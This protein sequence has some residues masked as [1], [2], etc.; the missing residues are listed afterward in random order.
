MDEGEEFRQDTPE[1]EG[2]VV[3]DMDGVLVDSEPVHK[4]AL[5]GV[6][7]RRGLRI[8]DSEYV[9]ITGLNHE[10]FWRWI[11]DNFSLPA[12]AGSYAIEYEDLLLPMLATGLQAA[13][14]VQK[15]I[16]LLHSKGIPMAV[17]SSSSRRV[18]D[19]TLSTIGLSTAFRVVLSGRDVRRGK[20]DPEIYLLA[21]DRL[22][23]RPADCVAVEDSAYGMAAAKAAGMRVIGVPGLCTSS[24]ELAADLVVRS[25]TQLIGPDG[26]LDWS[27]L[28]LRPR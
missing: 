17:A 4:R 10:S 15:V 11:V 5:Q 22:G 26:G 19:F 8:T 18:V 25:L 28:G 23:V 27:A 24:H 7:A 13:E 2:A 21:A 9:G 14:G 12:E 16:Q 3:F 6:L 20:P 1:R